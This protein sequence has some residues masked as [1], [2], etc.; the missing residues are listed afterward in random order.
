LQSRRGHVLSGL[1]FRQT[2]ESLKGEQNLF[3]VRQRNAYHVHP[4]LPAPAF[5]RRDLSG[6]VPQFR[7][8]LKLPE[9]QARLT[10]DDV[11]NEGGAPQPFIETIRSDIE[12][13]RVLVKQANIKLD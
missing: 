5:A 9:V 12:R 7:V 13:W 8:A 6:R 1:A 3:L 10:Q 11:T 4:G 2:F